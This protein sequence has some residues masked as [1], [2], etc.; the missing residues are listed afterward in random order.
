MNTHALDASLAKENSASSF[1]LKLGFGLFLVVFLFYAWLAPSFSVPGRWAGIAATFSGL[2]PFRPVIRPVW[3]GLVALLAALPIANLGAAINLLTSLAGA[4]CCW[5]LYEIVRRIPFERSIYSARMISWETQ[6]RMVA[7]LSA[8]LYAAV[9]TPMIMLS[10]YG[11]YAV[12]DLCLLLLAIYPVMLF[13]E[14]GRMVYWYVSAFLMGLALV[15][16]PTATLLLPL[17][18]A[19]WM[20]LLWLEKKL[21]LFPVCVGLLLSASGGAALLVYISNYL[22]SP[23]A[24][25]RETGEFLPV[26]AEFVRLYYL[27]LTRTVPKV[28]WLL[29]IGLH[30]VPFVA[31]M[32]RELSEPEDIFTAIGVYSFRF[33]L[34]LV[35]IV[36]LF[37]LPGSPARIIGPGTM[38]LAPTV[39]AA[40]W[41]GYLIG[42][43][44]G[45][46][47]FMP[48]RAG[49]SVKSAC[50][51]AAWLGVL[52][53]AGVR[54]GS[55]ARVTRLEPVARFADDVIGSL[56]GRDFLLTDGSLDS[57]LL[58]ASRK[59]GAKVNLINLN[60]GASKPHGRYHAA[61]FN[62]PAYH[63][64]AM[65]GPVVLMRDWLT[66]EPDARARTALLTNPEL[67]RFPG[68][69]ARP[70]SCFYEI[71][72]LE[73]PLETPSA[74]RIASDQWMQRSVPDLKL[75]REGDAGWYQ[76]Q[77]VVRWLSRLANDHGY[78]LDEALQPDFAAEA[79]AQALRFWPD[80]VS[81]MF[82]QREQAIRSGSGEREQIEQSIRS[83]AEKNPLSVNVRYLFAVCGM[84]RNPAALLE[85]MTYSSA[86]AMD[87]F[88]LDE[89]SRSLDKSDNRMLL[90]MARLYLR[91]A[92]VDESEAIYASMLETNPDN[93]D[94]LYGMFQVAMIRRN[95]D[96]AATYLDRMQ[97]LGVPDDRILLDRAS[98][99]LAREDVQAAR[100]LYQQ[101]VRESDAPSEA[102]LGLLDIAIREKD[103]NSIQA[104][105][106]ALERDRSFVPGQ[107]MLGE[108]SMLLRQPVAAREYFSR[109]LA[110]DPGHESALIRLLQIAFGMRD[111]AALRQHSGALL[112][113]RPEHPYANF[114]AGF[115]HIDSG[116]YDLAEVALRR[117]VAVN[118]D[119]AALNELAYV[120]SKQGK[121]AEAADVARRAVEKIPQNYNAWDTLAE[122]ERKLGRL[123]EAVIAMEEAIRL[124]SI[125]DPFVLIHAAELFLDADQRQ[126]SSEM[127]ALI[128]DDALT[129]SV[130]YQE[131]MKK[132]SEKLT[133]Y[134]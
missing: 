117:S 9:S 2:D 54:Q 88:R 119:G 95:T 13:R 50:L 65:L 100:A 47:Q 10:A 57:S 62:D 110:L 53:F 40:I 90:N 108:R 130:E 98:I 3:S 107:F 60:T 8:A 102:W 41:S 12:T 16:Y 89:V 27:E 132:L 6:P 11:D 17:F 93:L 87:P 18:C 116:D 72:S 82:N 85:N 134:P 113:L 112:L 36:T 52:I 22:D 68:I 39:L 125:A 44:Y 118:E 79:Y 49:G 84:V 99:R 120:L 42:Y 43:L 21:K 126:R 121:F 123:Q 15:E 103:E 31:V 94:A 32:L 61:M 1:A 70:A 105:F 115:V 64:T 74:Y 91:G 73:D 28:G 45:L 33:V 80:N 58:L 46:V 63:M 26:V 37:D 96:S 67:V 25:F 131:R 92:D 5:L 77:F 81:A 51:L 14:S 114:M 97:A 83:R 20:Y 38:L 109:V 59:A 124:N 128:D 48:G 29:I 66:R 30:V 106:S 71:A 7:G 35:A 56:N 127:L 69:D 34:A 19:A 4:S 101:L 24:R 104:A 86:G 122:A 55:A 23:V 111:V 75:F 133:R 78:L 76:S 129:S